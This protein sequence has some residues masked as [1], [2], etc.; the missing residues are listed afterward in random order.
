MFGGFD[1][2]FYNDLHILHTNKTLKESVRIS[3][4]TLHANLA[5]AVDCSEFSDIEFVL[6]PASDFFEV[7]ARTQIFANKSL[8]LYR[9]IE[10]EL[11]TT[12]FNSSNAV[13]KMQIPELLNSNRS[14]KALTTS[15]LELDRSQPQFQANAFLQK[16][17]NARAGEQVLLSE[18]NDLQK[19]EFLIFLEFCHCEKLIKP[20]TCL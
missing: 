9:L 13:F 7:A 1:G 11:R 18:V 4:S 17:F 16:V 10:R 8:V 14:S 12:D 5:E 19:E 3:K 6:K 2:T 20:M 15:R